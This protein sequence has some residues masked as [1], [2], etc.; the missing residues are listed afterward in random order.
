MSARA[1]H[2]PILQYCGKAPTLDVG[3]GRAAAQST[4]FHAWCAQA[5]EAEDLI[6]LLSEPERAELRSWAKPTPFEWQG[7][8]VEYS[9]ALTEY[10]VGITEAGDACAVTDPNVLVT[11]HLDMLWTLDIAGVRYALIGDI[12]RTVFTSTTDTL[13]LAAYGFAAAAKFDCDAYLPVLW[14]PTD[15]EWIVGKP[16]DLT[17]REAMAIW[18]R[19][20]LAAKREPTEYSTGSH[21]SGCWSRTRCPAHMVQLAYDTL[22]VPGTSVDQPTPEQARQLLLDY[23]RHKDTLEAAKS[24]LDAYADANGGIPDGQG[25]VWRAVPQQGRLGVASAAR[26]REVLGDTAEQFIVRGAGFSQHKWV[27]AK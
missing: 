1:S 16:V 8:R 6:A 14:I 26:L 15:G 2:L 24:W 3:S 23:Y 20:V 11:G 7:A 4:A 5:P 25:K 19:I 27:K 12:K 17:S 10:E 22:V 13:Q 9:A 18:R 21:C